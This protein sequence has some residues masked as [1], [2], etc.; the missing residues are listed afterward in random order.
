MTDK[1]WSAKPPDGDGSLDRAAAVAHGRPDPD[2]VAVTTEDPVL[3]RI[4][5][6]PVVPLDDPGVDGSIEIKCEFDN[7]TGS[8]KDRI[9]LGMI[10]TLEAR[11]SLS[12]GD[13]VVEASSGN[14]AGAV[15]LVAN[16]LG[17]DA[18]ITTPGGNSAQKLGYVEALGAE[19]VR[20]PDVGSDDD[21]YY[22]HEAQ[23]IADERGG[24][25]LDQ[26]SNQLN[27]AV[28]A[29]WTGPEITEQCPALTHVVCPMGTG[30]T[31][32]GIAT[33]VKQ[34]NPSVT[35]VGVDAADSNI[36]SAFRGEAPGPYDTDVEGL[37]QHSAG[38]TMWFEYIDDVRDVSDE[39]AFD[40]TR[41]LASEHGLLVG[42]S[43]GA[44][45]AVARSIA[46]QDPTATVV[47]IACDGGE[48]YFDTVFAPDGG[49]DHGGEP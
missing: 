44:A 49:P 19:L 42:P 9:A 29:R 32:S 16:R 38:P 2:T 14:T 6:T 31:L 37:G 11:G 40:E 12:T 35:T 39:T 25:W 22:R 47:T 13:L 27:P 4:G 36:S 15:A 28:H 18:V 23:R 3:D 24:V 26:Y 46:T 41:R 8:M 20:C 48:Q 1:R 30:G 45:V 43:S 21:R 17:Y 7:P 34:T 33:H 10:A 5:G